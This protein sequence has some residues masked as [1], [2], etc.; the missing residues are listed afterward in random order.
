MISKT[1][2]VLPWYS[3]E[4][5]PNNGPVCCYLPANANIDQIKS[6]LLQG[7]ESA[8]CEKC[9]AVE[10]QG[11]QS[12]RQ[13]ENIFLD[14]KLDKDIE[15]IYQ[16]CVDGQNQTLVYQITLSNRCNQACV[17]CSSQ[18]SS[19]WVEFEK[20][21]Q[22]GSNPLFTQ[23]IDRLNIDYAH[24]QRINILGGEPLFEPLTYQVLQ[25]LLDH[26]N[27]QCFVS[28]VTNGSISLDPYQ[29]E[30]FSSF[31]DKNICVS[32]DGIESRFEYLRW[33]G[34]WDNLQKNLDAYRNIPNTN[35]SVSY[36]IGALN[37]IYYDETVS[38]FE[39][40]KLKFN[41]NWIY[42]PIWA[43]MNKMPVVLKQRLQNHNVLAYH[44]AVTGQEQ[45]AEQ[46]LHKIQAQD[47]AKKISVADF[48]PDLYELLAR[49]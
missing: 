40:Q 1:F 41:H 33:P 4:V 16:D 46:L 3:R 30:L 26:G 29:T 6:D 2:C 14:Y 35:V 32:I 49:Q 19:R 25:K 23:D 7:I 38:W 47:R 44:A 10:R 11:H 8:A 31:K 15:K 28:L 39:Q 22:V 18:F 20:R 42:T 36:T 12:R 13:Q 21:M 43:S 24:A 5:I 27:D 45:T 9:W 37:A 17:T 48:M 34:K